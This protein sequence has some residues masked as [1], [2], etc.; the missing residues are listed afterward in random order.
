MGPA[1]VDQ[2]Y[3]I[4]APLR[5]D[6][7]VPIYL[8][9]DLTDAS[10][11]VLKAVSTTA[12]EFLPALKN[13]FA[14]LS[15]LNHPGI[16]R[17]HRLG[18]C[19][20][21]GHYLIAEHIRGLPLSSLLGNISTNELRDILIQMA[22]VLDYLHSWSLIHRDISPDNI[23][24]ERSMDSLPTPHASSPSITATLI[25][26]GFAGPVQPSNRFVPQGTLPFMAPEV[27]R[28]SHQDQR[29]DLYSL[30]KS[31]LAVRSIV[32]TSTAA[33]VSGHHTGHVECVDEI[34]RVA[35]TKLTQADPAAR[36]D[37]SQELIHALL[38]P[39]RDSPLDTEDL[40]RRHLVGRATQG[41]YDILRRFAKLL[42]AYNPSHSGDSSLTKRFHLVGGEAG[43]GKSRL[44]DEIR[45]DA[46]LH[47]ITT[48]QVICNARSPD[49]LEG[50]H[51]LV[52]GCRKHATAPQNSLD[53]SS[54]NLAI[55]SSS[56]RD[57]C[58]RDSTPGSLPSHHNSELTFALHSL[59]Q[60]LS[61]IASNRP[62]ALFFDNIQYADVETLDLIRL[63]TAP[64]HG[65]MILATYRTNVPG[66]SNLHAFLRQ[67]LDRPLT[68][69]YLL[70]RLSDTDTKELV[71]A[72]IG[73]SKAAVHLGERIHRLTAGN[74]LLV[75]EVLVSL[76]KSH[77]IRRE[78]GG[79]TVDSTGIEAIDLP[80]NLRV[81]AEKLLTG[82]PQRLLRL[83]DVI[84]VIRVR[85][86]FAYLSEILKLP[87][88][89]LSDDLEELVSS[90]LIIRH[91]P[92]LA[93]FFEF[94]HQCI[95]DVV[96]DRLTPSRRREL[97]GEIAELI[98]RLSPS[99]TPDTVEELAHHFVESMHSTKGPSYAFRAAGHARDRHAP[100]R[101][102]EL[103]LK[104]LNLVAKD[105]LESRFACLETLTELLLQVGD[106][107]RAQRF[108]LEM[109]LLARTASSN[110]R[111]ALAIREMSRCFI[112]RGDMH[113]GLVYAQDAE[114]RFRVLGDCSGEVTSMFLQAQ[115]YLKLGDLRP[116]TELAEKG[117]ERSLRTG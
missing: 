11:V 39:E 40:I 73:S 63:L 66:T 98:E 57:P 46:E 36:F 23:L 95:K 92:E 21:F 85:T 111:E 18:H 69:H 113:R 117:Y 35:L 112:E 77:L 115:T 59:A 27:L 58:F 60:A 68:E 105:D 44:L 81:F 62:A 88:A 20:F 19:R 80:S 48:C 17:V 78:R 86:S 106:P 94:R 110:E 75:E 64:P 65:A 22:L 37:N 15:H 43:V 67:F 83:L 82:L 8:A 84:A 28:S 38:D 45:I 90:G 26:F 108:C 51:F 100:Q 4:L 33:V 61:D 5:P 114:N 41:R 1:I 47:G 30:G 14:V 93:D 50:L 109:L 116:A 3:R 79:W 70:D 72:A 55:S 13:E 12:L 42:E 34:L 76:A 32:A 99:P 102:I 7:G 6:T 49:S 31:L 96:Y 29:S 54:Q 25:D 103:L 10:Q 24:V 16:R 107:S 9:E 56:F 91:S 2:R 74:P 53:N 97:H 104:G 89:G 52:E 71:C 101:A 87:A